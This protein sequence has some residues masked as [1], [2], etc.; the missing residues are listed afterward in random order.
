MQ[1]HIPLLLVQL[2]PGTGLS[3]LPCQNHLGNTG[4]SQESQGYLASMLCP[5][6]SATHQCSPSNMLEGLFLEKNE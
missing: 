6:A 4:R 5:K 2:S 3:L 1:L